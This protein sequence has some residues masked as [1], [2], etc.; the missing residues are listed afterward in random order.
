ME[1]KKYIRCIGKDEKIHIC[2]VN[3]IKTKCGVDIRRKKIT[4]KDEE[5]RYSCYA[6]TY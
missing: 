4:Q 5:K 6:C 3:E 2:E 1:Q